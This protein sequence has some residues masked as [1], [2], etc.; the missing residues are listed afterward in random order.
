MSTLKV[1][2][3][4]E[5]TSG[6][7]VHIAGH[8]IQVVNAVTTTLFNT[9][10]SSYVDMNLQASITP[11]SAS[12]KILVVANINVGIYASSYLAYPKF[13][14]LR[15]STTL[16]DT[17]RTHTGRADQVGNFQQS[18]QLGWS[19]LDSPSTTSSTTYKLQMR[20][21][22]SYGATL[23]VQD[24]YDITLMEIAQ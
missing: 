22:T 20:N 17:E 13:K 15:G 18:A 3:L 10:S 11:L 5:K 9:T 8:V 24:K 21:D 14:I 16:S 19:Y 12:S 4:V 6:N 1:D 2:S 23:Y 7:G